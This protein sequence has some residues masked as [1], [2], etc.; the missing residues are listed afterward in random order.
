[1]ISR[2]S[3]VIEQV[4]RFDRFYEK[5][6]RKQACA[7]ANEDF[8]PADVA[9][10]GELLWTDGGG[11]GAWLSYRLDLDAG[12]LSRVVKKL[13]SNGLLEPIRSSDDARTRTWELTSRGRDFAESIEAE[14][15]DRAADVLNGVFPPDQARLVQAM[16]VI[17]EILGATP[18]RDLLDW[19]G[20]TSGRGRS[21]WR[22]R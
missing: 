14:F 13:E 17:E 4:R 12:Y 7:A 2:D 3:K 22:R 16:R 20:P 11:T 5:R 21:R 18:V 9:V 8:S 15:R 10:L 19:R 1:M 6:L